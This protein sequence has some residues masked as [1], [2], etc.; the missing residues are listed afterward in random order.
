M[1]ARLG[2][3][4]DAWL[5]HPQIADV[6][7]LAD[8]VPRRTSCSI[9]VGGQ[10]G[11]RACKRDEVFP[12]WKASIEELAKRP[13]VHVKLGGQGMRLC[14]FGFEKL[15]DPPSSQVLADA[16]RPY[17]ET[18]IAAFGTSRAMFESNFPVDKGSY[19]Y[20]VFWNAAKMLAKGA[21]ATKRPIS[22]RHREAVLSPGHR[23]APTST[24]SSRAN[25]KPSCRFLSSAQASSASPSRAAR[26]SADE[27]I[28]AEA[29]GGIGNGVSS[30]NSEVIHAAAC[31]ADRL[32][33]R[34]D[35]RAAAA[36]VLYEFCESTACRTAKC[37]KLIVAID[38][39]QTAKIE[40]I[41]EA[42]RDQRRRG[43]GVHRR[44]RG[45]H[46]GAG[47]ALRRG[48]ALARDRHHRQP[49]L[50]AGAARRCSKSTAA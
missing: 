8:A 19:S 6:T 12:G 3:T 36:G 31:Y 24:A 23:L 10:V 7:A 40:G 30:R 38:D 46:H 2:Y 11:I 15:D 21:S 35:L 25:T 9:T 14:G 47:A 45:A 37:G 39:K 26:R 28:V 29:T 1:L 18:C 16:W 27:V 32:A 41:A 50:H 34:E 22:P 49:R 33:A 17:M 48:A 43:A 5:Y 13:N 44:Q 42:R 20:P 4:F